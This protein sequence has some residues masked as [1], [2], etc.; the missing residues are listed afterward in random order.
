MAKDSIKDASKKRK[1][2]GSKSPSP[3]ADPTSSKVTKSKSD[4]KEKKDKSEKKE[5]KDKSEKK[6]KKEKKEKVKKEKSEDVEAADTSMADVDAD[7]AVEDVKMEVDV[8]GDSTVPSA[9]LVAFAKPLAEGKLSKKVLKTTKKAAKTKALK[10]GVKEV[11]KALRK[12][13]NYSTASKPD[14]KT[15]PLLIL[16]ADISPPDV[17]SHLPVLAEDH[18]IPYIFVTSRAELGAAGATK[19][20][21]SVVMI[22]PESA[23]K[24]KSKKEKKGEDG[25]KDKG[26]D[27]IKEDEEEFR[28]S[29]K[30]LIKEVVGIT[31]ALEV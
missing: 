28:S 17:I 24:K 11:V 18:G 10:R 8:E 31:K 6:E 23:G 20:P 16:A 13:P 1:R 5:K 3:L 21:T 9:A 15:L 2:D 25:E 26:L 27:K 7:A 22:T 29:Y 19:R 4:K 12:S 30:D 14:P